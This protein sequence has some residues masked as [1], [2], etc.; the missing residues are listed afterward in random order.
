VTEF[1]AETEFDEV[2][3]DAT[4]GPEPPVSDPG[5]HARTSGRSLDATARDILRDA[6]A[7][8][9]ERNRPADEGPTG[10]DES[11]ADPTG[12]ED[13]ADRKDS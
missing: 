12:D 7:L 6:Q 3:E 1:A 4:D 10:V 13:A 9:R 11:A 5:R 2:F 8:T